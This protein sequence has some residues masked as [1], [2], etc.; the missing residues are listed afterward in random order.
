MAYLK[1]AN[2]TFEQAFG[3]AR[4]GARENGMPDAFMAMLA[5][6]LRGRKEWPARAMYMWIRSGGKLCALTCR[7]DL[8]QPVIDTL[9]EK[10]CPFVLAK[11]TTGNTGFLIR[12]ADSGLVRDA[13]EE[14]LKARSGYCEITTGE[15]AGIIY[16]R[17]RVK[18]KSMLVLGGLSEEEVYY[19]Q[20]EARW[21]ACRTDHTP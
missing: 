21:T 12:E 19:L 10:G 13:V 11:E 7:E 2:S 6:Y 3:A 9:T 8:V 16:R 4:G 15:M 18:D 14:M 17:A 1:L 20:E 5:D